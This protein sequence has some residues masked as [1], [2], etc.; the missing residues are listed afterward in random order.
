MA[1]DNETRA[2]R[3]CLMKLSNQ[4]C[5]P[6]DA[7]HE[8][9]AAV[10][11][12][13]GPLN[14]E[15]AVDMLSCIVPQLEAL[16]AKGKGMPSI[17]PEDILVLGGGWYQLGGLHR[18]WE[19]EPIDVATSGTRRLIA[20]TP[21]LSRTGAAPGTLG[22]DCLPPELQGSLSLPLS[23]TVEAT[24]FSLAMLIRKALGIQGSLAP[25]AGSKL[26]YCL[27]RCLRPEPSKRQLFF[28]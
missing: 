16:H 14:Y 11:D 5:D 27:K 1:H 15:D 10:L 6:S 24:Y 21:P 9:L 8:T 19:L 26:Y 12:S 28:I 2:V 7:R 17:E 23:C 4:Q 18:A 20:T 25:L 22:G 3:D 13:H